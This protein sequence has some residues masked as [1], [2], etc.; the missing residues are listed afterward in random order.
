MVQKSLAA[1]YWPIS[2]SHRRRNA[3][4]QCQSSS[5]VTEMFTLVPIMKCGDVSRC[6]KT[7]H[8]VVLR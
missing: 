6:D 8:F 1:R 2:P 4:D 3:R 7:D 5:G